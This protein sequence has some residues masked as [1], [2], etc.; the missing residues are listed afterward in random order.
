[1]EPEEPP[2]NIQALE[3]VGPG[4]IVGLGLG[5]LVV[6]G[7]SLAGL[8]YVH[9]KKDR[10]WYCSILPSMFWASLI[11]GV[12]GGVATGVMAISAAKG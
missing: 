12:V 2:L 6:Y 3:G 1:M 8:T 7:A 4:A 9:R 10:S 11:T 5:S